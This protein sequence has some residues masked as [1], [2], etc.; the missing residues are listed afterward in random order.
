MSVRAFVLSWLQAAMVVVGIAAWFY[1]VAN[2]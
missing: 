1:V 2:I